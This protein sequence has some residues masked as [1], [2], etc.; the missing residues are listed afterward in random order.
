VLEEGAERFGMRICEFSVQGNHVHL[1]TEAEDAR[2]LSLSMQGLGIR[3]AK[4][5]NKMMRRVGRV[6]ADRFHARILRTPTEVVRVLRYV[7]NN[8]MVHRAR[9]ERRAVAPGATKF[10]GEGALFAKGVAASKGLQRDGPLSKGLPTSPDPCSSATLDHG[11]QLPEART[12]L[13][14]RAQGEA[15]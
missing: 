15:T 4:G 9:W 13:L 14:R 6:L 11:I 1:L 3:L 8:R 7:R 2:A 10:G 12:Y 5:L